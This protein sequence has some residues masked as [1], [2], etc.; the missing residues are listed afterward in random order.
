M[1]PVDAAVQ[2]GAMRKVVDSL[3]AGGAA[4]V[5]VEGGWCVIAA[6]GSPLAGALGEPFWM[7]PNRVGMEKAASEQG[8]VPIRLIRRL[9][10]GP[11]EFRFAEPLREPPPIQGRGVRAARLTG[12]PFTLAVVNELLSGKGGGEKDLLGWELTDRR[13]VAP[14][15]IEE[16][17]E[18]AREAGIEAVLAEGPEPLGRLPATIVEVGRGAAGPGLRVIRSGAYEERYIRKQLAMNILF[19]CTGNTCR[20]PMAE[21]IASALRDGGLGQGGAAPVKFGSAGTAAGAGGPASAEAA[22]AVKGLNIGASLRGHRS[23]PLTR[24]LI[25][26]ADAI[27]TMGRSHLHAILEMDP[28]AADRVR[29]LDPEGRDVPDPVGMPDDVYEATARSILTMWR[30]RMKEIGQ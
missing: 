13:G 22:R 9:T 24:K 15:T 17:G 5:P 2:P 6:A 16:A 21:A 8:A 29:L 23:R 20:S 3:L 18:L 12:H 1:T 25:E 27:F 30:A 11:V 10:P 26:E 7:A 19:V 4:V 28:D 14:S